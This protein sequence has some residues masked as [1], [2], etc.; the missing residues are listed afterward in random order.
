M[1]FVD[2]YLIRLIAL[3]V[4]RLGFD[5]QRGQLGLSSFRKSVQ[6]IQQRFTQW[7]T[8]D[9]SAGVQLPKCE[10]ANLI[11]VPS[12]VPLKNSLH[13]GDLIGYLSNSRRNLLPPSS[14]HISCYLGI[15]AGRFLRNLS[16][17]LPN[18]K[19]SHSGN[20]VK[21]ILMT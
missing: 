5:S 21:F 6:T 17:C 3:G 7:V 18:C 14:R 1:Y 2:R 20:K 16:T 9:L 4:G 12:S 15:G 10:N 19:V 8:G 13:V 11:V